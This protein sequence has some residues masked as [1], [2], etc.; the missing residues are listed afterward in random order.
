MGTILIVEDEYAIADLL[1]MVLSDAG[2]QTRTAANG[3]EALAQLAEGL[4]PNLII[5]DL[6]MP[7]LNGAEMIKQLRQDAVLRDIP[8]VLMSSIP[9]Q[10]VLERLDGYSAFLRKPFSLMH[11][12]PLVTGILSGKLT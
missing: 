3:Q 7:V 4:R 2:Y 11:V 5:T 8:Y 9:E 1:E 10:Q 12:V 6:M